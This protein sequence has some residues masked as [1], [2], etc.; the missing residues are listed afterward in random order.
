MG[1]PSESLVRETHTITE[2]S[3]KL[4]VALASP[5]STARTTEDKLSRTQ[6]AVSFHYPPSVPL[7][8]SSDK[9]ILTFRFQTKITAGITHITRTDSRNTKHMGLVTKGTQ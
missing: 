6:E 2:G 9:H 5:G 8:T 1:K 4:P 7:H 3:P